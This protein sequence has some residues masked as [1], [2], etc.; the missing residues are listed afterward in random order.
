MLTFAKRFWNG[1]RL[2]I[3]LHVMPNERSARLSIKPVVSS[4][5]I[6]KAGR[7]ASGMHAIHYFAKNAVSDES[8]LGCLI[9][10]R[11]VLH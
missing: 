1:T 5:T 8:R 9:G 11:L 3:R 6:E 7:K 2:A 10:A 4:E